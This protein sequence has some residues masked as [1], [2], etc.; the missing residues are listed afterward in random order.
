M[1]PPPIPAEQAAL[2]AAIVAE[3]DDDT[4]R[5]VYADWL[6]EHS[7]AEQAA[8]IRDSIKLS[9][10]KPTAKSWKTLYNR[11][12]NL[13]RDSGR[14]WLKPLGIESG[15]PNFTRG[16]AE[17]LF[18]EEPEDYFRE[19]KAIF[20]FL[21]IEHLGFGIGGG[22]GFT[23]KHLQ[24]L[25]KAP[26]LARLRS[27]EL[28]DHM[29]CRTQYW[30]KFFHSP[31]LKNLT[32]LRIVG[33]EFLDGEVEALASSPA[34]KNLGELELCGMEVGIGGCRALAKSRHLKK[35]EKLSIIENNFW[36]EFEAAVDLLEKRFADGLDCC[37]A[38]TD[39]D[40][41]DE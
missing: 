35:L 37:E 12:W 16:L 17:S 2:L 23:D 25:A 39:L 10:T 32:Y 11:L 33:C 31:H 9:L 21:P 28:H 15:A 6:E 19:Q 34:L 38:D 30:K 7:D 20:R 18:Y 5:L 27:L 3:P 4:P 14:K 40:E 1:A 41:D 24:K 13:E 26:E 8:F 29:D 22:T 36:D